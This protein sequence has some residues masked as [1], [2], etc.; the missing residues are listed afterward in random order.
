M[1]PSMCDL[2]KTCQIEQANLENSSTTVHAAVEAT[3][4]DEIKDKAQTAL[5]GEQD[6]TASAGRKDDL[7]YVRSLQSVSCAIC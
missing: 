3:A 1:M 7:E 5:G 2:C 4:A 6:L